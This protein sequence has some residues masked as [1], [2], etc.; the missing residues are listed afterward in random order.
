[1]KSGSVEVFHVVVVCQETPPSCRI[2]RSVSRL[3]AATIPSRSRCSRSLVNDQVENPVR[4]QSVG[5]VRAI[6][7]DPVPELLT[8]P[9]AASP[10]RFWVQR[11]EPPLVERVDHIAHVVVADLQ[12]RGDVAH[13][14]ALAG[15]HHHDARRIRTGFFAVRVIRRS[16]WPSSMDDART[17]TLGLRAT[18][19][20]RT[21][22]AGNVPGSPGEI[23]YLVDPACRATSAVTT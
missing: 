12:Q 22:R 13:G 5:D 8:D 2:R 7:G 14:L 11:L 4:P 19:T 21:R 9:P 23:N 18:P 15:H 1:M 20:S 3:I 10:A 6:V 16:F 17:N